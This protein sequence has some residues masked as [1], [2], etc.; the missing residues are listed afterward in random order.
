[1]SNRVQNSTKLYVGALINW[2]IQLVWLWKLESIL[3][4]VFVKTRKSL[5]NSKHPVSPLIHE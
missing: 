2:F 5:L 4:M 3:S 1:V